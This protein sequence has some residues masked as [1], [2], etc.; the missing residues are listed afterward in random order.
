MMEGRK[1]PI[2]NPIPL[3]KFLESAP[4]QDD[5]ESRVNDW[6]AQ[7][8][9]IVT[10]LRKGKSAFHFQSWCK[11]LRDG[12]TLPDDLRHAYGFTSLEEFDRA[13]KHWAGVSLQK[14]VRPTDV[15]K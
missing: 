11:A 1:T 5:P 8:A 15:P 4:M 6:Y 2:T 12:E 3:R 9:S 13:W 14:E 10:F 7:A